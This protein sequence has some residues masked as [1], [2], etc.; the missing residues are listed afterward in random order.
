MDP[1]YFAGKNY[2]SGCEKIGCKSSSE[3]YIKSIFFKFTQCLVR[4]LN[5][6]KENQN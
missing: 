1:D 5:T 3:K 2:H 4:K 6:K